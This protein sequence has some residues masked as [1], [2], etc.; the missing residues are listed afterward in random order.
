MN[1]V[2]VC[3]AKIFFIPILVDM[4]IWNQVLSC[5]DPTILAV[6]LPAGIDAQIVFPWDVFGSRPFGLARLCSSSFRL[7]FAYTPSFASGMSS[8]A[9]AQAQ[10]ASNPRR[11]Q[12]TDTNAKVCPV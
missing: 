12:R 1:T 10:I 8:A 2:L 5:F 6:L 9:A 4:S 3:T 7:D 11:M